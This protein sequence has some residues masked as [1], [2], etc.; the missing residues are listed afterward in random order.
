MSEACECCGNKLNSFEEVGNGYC[1]K[2][3]TGQCPTCLD[4]MDE[5]NAFDPDS[6]V[7]PPD[8]R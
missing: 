4:Y 1:N 3:Y 8:E 2:C 6:W 7:D 5:E